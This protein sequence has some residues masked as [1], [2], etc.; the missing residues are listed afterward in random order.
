VIGYGDAFFMLTEF[1]ALRPADVVCHHGSCLNGD[2]MRGL[3]ISPEG[4]LRRVQA[5][6]A[7]WIAG[8]LA[9][10]AAASLVAMAGLLAIA[11]RVHD[12]VPVLLAV[13][14]PLLQSRPELIF[15]GESRTGYQVDPALAAQL[16]G[17]PRGAAVNIAYEAGEPLA[18]LAAMRRKPDRFQKADVVVSVA[19]FLFNEGVRSAAVYPLD[20]VA[21]LGV[22]E[23][24]RSFLPL[25][26][27]TLI[28]YIREAFAAHLAAGQNVADLGAPPPALGLNIIDNTQPG[29]RW[30]AELGSHPHYA[31]WDLSGPKARF[32][33]GALCDM[34]GLTRK[35]T[36]V[37]PPWAPR[38]RRSGDPSWRDKD[39]SYT[40]LVADAGRRCG[41]DVLNIR[42]IPGLQQDNYADEMH[43][44]ASGVPI[45][46]R[47]IV[48]RLQR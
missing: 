35:L 14:L 41:F 46:T 30:P 19:P 2:M 42:S 39:D 36:V 12:D 4:S 21:R 10:T 27:G 26:T 31:N 44:N 11:N 9:L 38:Y 40:A 7:R 22:A 16:I 25:R 20:V 1:G 48:S 28:R 8:A 13:K 45:Y 15:G 24:M 47:Y 34:V 32:E 33:I 18:L 3:S 37:V 17:K 23:Q 43:V 6:S 29:D 5:A